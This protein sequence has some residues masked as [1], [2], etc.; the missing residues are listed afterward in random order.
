MPEQLPGSV[1]PIPDQQYQ[2]PLFFDAKHPEAKLP[3]IEMNRPPAGA[4]NVLLVLLD[5]V[6][7]GASS[8]FGG[9]VNT[10]TA[11]QLA[12]GGLK[13]S[14]FHT[15]S[16][17]SPTRAAMLTGRNH[18]AVGMG[19]ITETATPAP[20]YRSTRPNSCTPLAEIVR[21]NGYNTAQF[22]KCHEVPVWESG[23]T[24]P[25]D[26][27][28]AFSGFERFYGFIGGETNQWQPALVDGVSAILPPDDPDYHL[29]P[30][31]ADKA[32]D[33]IKQQKALTPDKPFFTYF[34]P[35]ATH[36]PHHV[37]KDWIAKYKGKFDQGWDAVRDETFK[38]QLQL[39]VIGA[40]S[41]LT[42]RPDGIMA[43]DDVPA[44]RKPILAHQMEVYAAFLEYADFHVGRVVD[45][46]EEIGE[47]DNTLILYIIGDNGASAEGGLEG[48]YMITTASNGGGEYETVE[49]WNEHL[50]KMGGPE[51]YNHYAVGWAHAMCTPYQWTKQ[52]ASH[53]GGTRNGTI[54]HWPGGIEAK[55][56][57]RTQWHHVIDVAPT[58]LE[59]AGLA[60]PHTV[61][62]VTQVPMHGTSFAYSFDAADADERHK[63]QYFELM[64]NRGIYHDGWTA[65]TK[66]RT[67]WDVV[68]QAPDFSLDVWELYDTTTDWTQAHDL[69]AQHPEKLAQLQQLFII[70]AARYNVLPLDDRAAE[71]MNPAIAGRPTLVQGDK[72]RLFEGMTRLGENVAI[73]IKNRSY[74]VTAQIQVP[75]DGAEGVVVTQGGRTGG[76]SL[77][78][79]GGKLGY[80]YNYCGLRRTTV[81]S[82][83]A[84][85]PGEHQVRVEF[86]YD[87]GG[88][89][90]GGTATIYVD[91]DEAG[92]G[93]VERTHP[94]YFSFDE[95]LDVGIDTGMPVY[96]GYKT[97]RGKFSGKIDWADIELGDD[98]HS[99]L[100]DPEDALAAVLKHQ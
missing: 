27:W 7:F 65:V 26:H 50:D 81:L 5:D 36:T 39:G 92:S 49:F 77:F 58:I 84:L 69:S 90:R 10:P 98:D 75:E 23:P 68:A 53:Y 17:C 24:G 34:A 63:T 9:P 18:H 54:M 89:G 15:T 41:D 76:W 32:I 82:E 73:N 61:N 43:W 95:G 25:F 11:E 47:L 42:A 33:Y 78:T 2:G 99:H 3:P 80:H 88:I 74:S 94:L 72:L 48:T 64:G 93:H 16:L 22:G 79:E 14:R 100:I 70:E 6:G 4:P 8:A 66:H 55:G 13:Y 35:G 29:M 38:K 56:E 21:Q 1:L 83:E 57:I 19:H 67:P 87:G 45:A 51:A 44:E 86:A 28:P 52:V 97:A 37:P 31:L 71:R 60:Q 46:V 85:T 20:G 62:G 91:G 59:L 30:D 40:D 12:A 96:E